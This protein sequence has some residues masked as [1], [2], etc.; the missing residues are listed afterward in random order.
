[1]T[2]SLKGN[3]LLHLDLLAEH[4]ELVGGPGLAEFVPDVIARL[5]EAQ[6]EP[7]VRDGPPRRVQLQD[8]QGLRAD[9]LWRCKE[10]ITRQKNCVVLGE[11]G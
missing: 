6:D 1:M 10:I 8:A 5:H 4:A 3:E 9:G 2:Y 7:V 11:N